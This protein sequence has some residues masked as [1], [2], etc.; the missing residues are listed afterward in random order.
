MCEPRGTVATLGWLELTSER[1]LS[2]A[3]GLGDGIVFIFQDLPSKPFDQ[4]SAQCSCLNM[5]RRAQP[6]GRLCPT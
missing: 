6:A 5:G 2:L 4:V 3:L 1:W